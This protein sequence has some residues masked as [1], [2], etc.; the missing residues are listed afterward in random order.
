MTN[1]IK[2]SYSI[3]RSPKAI[4]LA[5]ATAALAFS[6]NIAP[7]G[8]QY[9]NYSPYTPYG[10]TTIIEKTVEKEVTKQLAVNKQVRD[11]R[12]GKLVDNIN[13]Q[14]FNFLDKQEVVFRLTVTNNGS[15]DIN[16]VVVT[17]KLPKELTFVSATDFAY[18]KNNKTLTHKIGTLKKGEAKVYD[19]KT[20]VA[21]AKT[22][23]GVTIAFCPVNTVEV[24]GDNLS[25][26]DTSQVCVSDKVL[27]QVKTL[28]VT[29]Q[30][31]A[32]V[33]FLSSAALSLAA[34]AMFRLSRVR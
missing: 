23:G 15:I 6:A 3:V 2:T 30:A 17:D 4:V 20:K 11:P 16:N 9:S 8:A 34:M 18:D 29:G 27:G 32:G 33:L 28:P 5:L 31:E 19:I 25:S 12:N 7:V 10:T 1:K 26:S 21:V 24:K 14:E 13:T 22:K